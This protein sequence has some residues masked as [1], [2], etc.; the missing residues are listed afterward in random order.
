[1]I[2]AEEASGVTVSGRGVVRI[3][4]TRARAAFFVSETRT[5]LVESVAAADETVR[6]VRAALEGFGVPREDAATGWTGVHVDER[7]AY[8]CGHSLTVVVRDLSRVGEVIAGVFRAAERGAELHGVDF[9]VAEA[10]RGPLVTEARAKAWADARDRAEQHAAQA[11]RRLGSVTAVTESD[12]GPG[13]I[14]FADATA[15]GFRSL[16]VVPGE[17]AVEVSVRVTWSF[18]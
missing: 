1:V 17:F 6:R 5:D 18:A 4:P 11:G 14:R 16:D 3:P 2:L 10:E 13:G 7:G 9:D 8:R 15:G 12:L